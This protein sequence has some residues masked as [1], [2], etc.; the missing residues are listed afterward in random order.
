MLRLFRPYLSAA[1]L[2]VILQVLPAGAMVL[3]V[4][5]PKGNHAP[6]IVI[7]TSE[8][9]LY[10]YDSANRVQRFSIA[11]GR[12]GRKWSGVTAVSRKVLAPRWKPPPAVRKDN[13]KL[14]KI[15]G[16]G[17]N[18]P[19]GVAVLVLGDGTYGIHGNNNPAKIGT[20]ASYGCIRMYNSDI[21]YLYMKVDIGTKVT[22]I[23]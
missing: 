16:P 17:P 6:R 10:F 12:Q 20:D 18:N 1:L 15:V 2:L 13:P 19:L 22:V 23:P 14:P 3:S 7:K 11:V 4:S 9:A 5:P 8:H 21:L